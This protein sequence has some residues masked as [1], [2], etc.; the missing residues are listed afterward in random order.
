MIISHNI[1]ALQGY[2]CL[3]NNNAAM[4][5]SIERL[6]TG[7]R[8]N[9]ASDDAAGFAISEKM[10][11]QI[12][13]LDRAAANTQ[14][15]ISLLQTAEGALSSI[16][17]MIDRMRELSVQAANDTLTAEDRSYIQLELDE[18]KNNIDNISQTTQFNKKRILDGSS[19]ALWSSGD[20]KLK[21]IVGGAIL[22]KDQ[23]GQKVSAAGNYKIEI[24]AQAGEAQ[25]LK[26]NIMTVSK[27]HEYPYEIDIV[28]NIDSLG[29]TSG[30]GWN[31]DNNTLTITQDGAYSIIGTVDENGNV[32]ASNN[33]IV[34]SA[35]VNATIFLKDI[36]IDM[37]S[38]DSPALY[39]EA[40]GRADVYLSGNN[41]MLGGKGRAALEVPEG[42]T[43]IL[44]SAEGDGETEGTLTATGGGSTA[45]ARGG[46]AGIGGSVE[47]GQGGN[48]MI[49]GGTIIATGAKCAA[50]IGGG[51]KGDYSTSG[52]GGTI[53]ISGGNVTATGGGGAG[54]GNAAHGG[55]AT[56]Y[57]DIIITGGKVTARGETYTGTTASAGIGG[58]CHSHGKI[59]INIKAGLRSSGMVDA[60][61]KG[62][63]STVQDIGYGH[64]DSWSTPPTLTMNLDDSSLDEAVTRTQPQPPSAWVEEPCTLREI[65]QFYNASGAFLLNQ[66]QTI[67]INQGDGKSASVMLYANDTI[68]D[69]AKKINDAIAYDLNQ[70]QYANNSLNFCSIADGT[71]NTSE[72]VLTETPVYNDQAYET[73]AY[74]HYVLQDPDTGKRYFTFGEPASSL[75]RLYPDLTDE[76]INRLEYS[77]ASGSVGNETHATML[78]RS[79]VAGKAGE[80]TFSSSS[81]DLLNA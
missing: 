55:F 12:A 8:I 53:T 64:Y 58:S 73:D 36:N 30:S 7:L 47:T 60:K 1:P 40:G 74:G 34:V 76:I 71:A 43:L 32:T 6:S 46:G 16:S 75:K 2:K 29:R 48:I 21:A 54:I 10:R 27:P 63:S 52:G 15:G 65:S 11:S 68:Y 5:K 26:S 31:I 77:R 70:S 41:T 62:S 33:R 13:G 38:T 37:S 69:A 42:A 20:L 57:T 3:N 80:L 28:N 56:D 78:I 35:G 18:L 49:K 22:D 17:S 23:F 79:A 45:Y 24:T 81:Q 59:S 50:G 51:G 9:S 4:Q 19:C 25:V 39:V 14:D 67:T 61:S 44:S 66:P 72:S